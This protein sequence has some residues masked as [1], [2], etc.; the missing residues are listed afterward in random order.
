MCSNLCG[1][2]V[3]NTHFMCLNPECNAHFNMENRTNE[4]ESIINIKLSLTD[5]SGTLDNCILHHKAASKMFIEVS[6]Y[7]KNGNTLSNNSKL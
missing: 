5:I 7:E 6:I 3:E 4:L 2:E 1:A